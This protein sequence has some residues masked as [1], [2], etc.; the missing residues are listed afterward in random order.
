MSELINKKIV[1]QLNASWRPVGER[2][3]REAFVSLMGEYNGEPPQLALDLTT[4]RDENGND[5]LV[6]ARA[7][8]WD[9]W[10]TLPVREEDLAI[11]TSSGLI[12]VPLIL[13]ARNYNKVPVRR[14]RLSVG[15]VRERDGGICQ[16]TGRKLARGAGNID[17]IQPRSRGGKDVWTNVVWCDKD[18]NLAK[19]NRLNSE[20]GLKLLRQPKEPPAVPVSFHITEARHPAW[21]FFMDHVQESTS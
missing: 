16:Y 14:K 9:E 20:M 1:L 4:R 21:R 10:K 7:V 15:N 19:G 6:D 13:I 18:L 5:V 3:V 12:R 11:N 17:H 2:L 8:E